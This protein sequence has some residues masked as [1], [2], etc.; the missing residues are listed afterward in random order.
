M[1]PSNPCVLTD[2]TFD[3]EDDWDHWWGEKVGDTT[4]GGGLFDLDKIPTIVGN[5]YPFRSYYCQNYLA[6]RD[7]P[8]FPELMQKLHIFNL[9]NS[10]NNPTV[11][12]SYKPQLCV[13]KPQSPIQAFVNT[14]SILGYGCKP[15]GFRQYKS[16]V[17]ESSSTGDVSF[18]A[19]QTSTLSEMTPGYY[20]YVEHVGSAAHGFTDMFSPPTF[21]VGVLPVH[22]YSTT[23]TDDDIQDTTVIYKVD[24]AIEIEYSYDYILQYNVRGNAH[25]LY[26]GDKTY[27]CQC[28]QL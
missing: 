24:T 3:E 8:P 14:E 17:G 26:T 22:S 10:T 15:I 4:A 28:L 2:V 20:S 27:H 25:C 1:Q 16:S 12:W 7:V 23:P 9:E 18:G 6:L 11:A 21:H 13:L 5:M 19:E